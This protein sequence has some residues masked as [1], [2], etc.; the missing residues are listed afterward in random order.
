MMLSIKKTSL[1]ISDKDQTIN[2]P[3]NVGSVISTMMAKSFSAPAEDKD[4]VTV[5]SNS[6]MYIF[7]PKG[8]S[9]H[10]G[11]RQGKLE[12]P[13]SS[14]S[15]CL[16]HL[17]VLQGTR[18]NV[19][20]CLLELLLLQKTISLTLLW[21][22]ALPKFD[23]EN[24]G[25]EGWNLNLA[26]DFIDWTTWLVWALHQFN[27]GLFTFSINSK[28]RTIWSV[29]QTSPPTCAQSWLIGWWRSRRISSWIMK[30]C[31]W[32]SRWSTCTWA[33]KRC[34]A[35][36]CSCWVQQRSLSRQNLT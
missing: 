5:C 25:E 34:H 23:L 12:W 7:E 21:N 24:F 17:Q 31:T 32:L 9:G 33:R 19:L 1:D 29:K 2:M 16:W 10:W 11:R 20:L 18:G 36:I 6:C 15:L 4:F 30:P 22:K 26:K 8:G 3:T 35:K 14:Q 13:V 27:F 28:W